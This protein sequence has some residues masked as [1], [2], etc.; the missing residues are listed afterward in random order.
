M[1]MGKQCEAVEHFVSPPRA[2]VCTKIAVQGIDDQQARMGSLERIF[3]DRDIVE[4]QG[5]RLLRG[6][7]DDSA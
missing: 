1:P 5:G 3:E 6:I 2:D 4:T 7:G